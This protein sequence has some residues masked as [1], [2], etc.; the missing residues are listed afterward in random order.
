M[1]NDTPDIKRE[2]AWSISNATNHGSAS[3]VYELVRAGLLNVFTE[4]L[5][6]PDIKTL[7]VVLEAVNNV[8]KRGD[9]GPENEFLNQFEALGGIR[10]LE[11]L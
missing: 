10:K 6:C 9:S 2:A 8:L 3:D 5:D 4:M 7:V 1:R 11:L